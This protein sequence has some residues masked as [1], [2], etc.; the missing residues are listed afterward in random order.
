MSALSIQPPFPAFA[1]ADGQPLENGYIWIGTANLNPQIN[2]IAVY[3]DA[4][5]TI[6]A[7]QPIRTLNGYPSYQGTPARLYVNSDY[8]IQV[9]DSKGSLIY[10]ALAA[11]ERYNDV[12]VSMNA[13]NVSYDPAGTSAVATNVQA[14]LRESVSVFDFMTAA[15]VA[16]VQAKTKIYDLTIPLQAAI[17]SITGGTVLFPTGVYKFSKLTVNNSIELRGES[18]GNTSSD[19]FG[20]VQWSDMSWVHGTVLISTATSGY[21]LDFNDT[22]FVRQYRMTGILV[23]GPGTGTST[24]MR[25]GSVAIAAVE[26]KF[27][28]VLVTNFRTSHELNNLNECDI[29]LRSRGCDNGPTIQNAVNNCRVPGWE[30]QS[31]TNDVMTITNSSQIDFQSGIIQGA[32]GTGGLRI[33]CSCDNINFYGGWAENCASLNWL[34]EIGTTDT[35]SANTPSATFIGWRTSQN[36]GFYID[37]SAGTSIIGSRFLDGAVTITVNATGTNLIGVNSV[38]TDSS[39]TTLKINQLGGLDIGNGGLVLGT[40][41]LGRARMSYD[42]TT[43]PSAPATGVTVFC[44]YNSGTG[45]HTYFARFPT[46]A[47][48]ILAIEP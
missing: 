16:D 29:E 21:A 7:V 30:V 12:V 38:V 4:A 15:Q 41:A 24:G 39:V 45:K 48:Q 22:V 44:T 31:S 46:G 6:A 3:W 27:R 14:K 47:D 19:V 37:R 1:G 35:G 36:N 5:L 25:I 20:S 32:F 26:C 42:R 28:D 11:T 17:D 18:W 33:S 34:V 10:S 2:Q 40:T 23:I 8:S 9:L 43:V 13:A